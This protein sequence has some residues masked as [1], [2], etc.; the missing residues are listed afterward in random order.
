MK[1]SIPLSV[2]LALLAICVTASG[3]LAAGGRLQLYL[4]NSGPDTAFYNDS[5][6]LDGDCEQRAKPASLSTSKGTAAQFDSPGYSFGSAPHP[7]AFSYTVPA[8]Q[9]FQVKANN[10]AVMLKLWAFSGDGTAPN[11]PIRPSAPSSVT[12]R[13]TGGSSARAPAGRV[14]A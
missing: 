4:A 1:R 5:V 7:S 12:R 8:G 6:P 14:S 13:S 3:A 2:A 11:R 9:G 10:N